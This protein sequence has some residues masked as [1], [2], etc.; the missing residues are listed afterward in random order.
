MSLARRPS[1]AASP[2][3]AAPHEAWWRDRALLSGAAAAIVLSVALTLLRGDA[4]WG[5][6][7]GVYAYTA[8]LLLHGD[9]LY[10]R[11]VTEPVSRAQAVREV[12]LDFLQ[13]KVDRA[14]LPDAARGLVPFGAPTPA[15]PSLPGWTHPYYWAPFVLYGTGG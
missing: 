3:T 4:L 1:P 6:S 9:D 15:T 7:D 5:Q 10:G 14:H 12:Q 2:A 11:L 13:G 8:R